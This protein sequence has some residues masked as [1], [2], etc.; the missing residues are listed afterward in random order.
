MEYR[1]S[2]TELAR[3]LGDILGR[4][5][6]RGDTFV[7]ERNGDPIARLVPLPGKNPVTVGEAL[8]AWRAAGEPDPSFADDLERVSALDHIPED[9]WGS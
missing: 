6:Y 9:A 8:A 2:A 5:R 3:R 4:I 1:I 7:V